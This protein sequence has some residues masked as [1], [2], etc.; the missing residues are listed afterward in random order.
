MGTLVIKCPNTGRDI[1][2]GVQVDS[3]T[4][5]RMPNEVL[6]TRCPH[7]RTKHSWRP[8]DAKFVEALP[9]ADWIENQG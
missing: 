9:P 8:R 7:C 6:E 2:T 1:A 5:A 3:S 4:F